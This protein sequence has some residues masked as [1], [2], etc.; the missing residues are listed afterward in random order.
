M[1][2]ASLDSSRPILSTVRPLPSPFPPSTHPPTNPLPQQ[3][4]T[5]PSR[6]ST[7][8]QA[9]T[10][11]PSIAP[12]H[13]SRSSSASDAAGAD[14]R[15]AELRRYTAT[16]ARLTDARL[17]SQRF[18]VSDSKREEQLSLALGAKLER[19]LGRRMTGQDA[20]FRKKGAK[21]VGGGEKVSV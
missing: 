2:N 4:L 20:V 16:L 6:V 13:L 18:V 8:S 14:P 11:A 15:A 10:L 5:T 3:S 17:Q 7:Y 19:A 9:P 12:S 1:G 21:G